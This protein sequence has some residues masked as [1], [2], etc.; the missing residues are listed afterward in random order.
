M[1]DRKA[2]S[3]DDD[4]YFCIDVNISGG[5]A[6]FSDEPGGYPCLLLDF[7]LNTGTPGP[8]VA[9]ICDEDTL[10]AVA[11][12]ISK[13]ASRSIRKASEMST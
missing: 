4:T 7:A 13:A 5:V 10:I 8:K 9:L 2:T 12:G 1:T 6:P 11:A 3:L